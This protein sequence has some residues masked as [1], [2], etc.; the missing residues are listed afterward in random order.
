MYIQGKAGIY[1]TSTIR[2]QDIWCMHELQAIQDRQPVCSQMAKARLVH[3][4]I[5]SQPWR[6]NLEWPGKQ[7][8]AKAASYIRGLNTTF[9]ESRSSPLLSRFE[10]QSAIVLEQD[11]KLTQTQH[12]AA[13]SSSIRAGASHFRLVRPLQYEEARGVWGHAPPGTLRSLLRPCLGQNAT[14]IT[15]PVVSVAVEPSC[16][17]YLHARRVCQLLPNLCACLALKYRQKIEKPQFSRR[18]FGCLK[19]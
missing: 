6:H 5:L 12:S 17:K 1:F 19:A 18:Y 11:Q 2:L 16:Q 8:Q 13:P 7:V 9:M 14:R 3:S 15:P 4:Q 10:L